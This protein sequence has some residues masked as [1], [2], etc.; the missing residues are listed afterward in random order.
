M[1]TL[2]RVSSRSIDTM[3][4]A[5]TRTSSRPAGLTSRNLFDVVFATI[6]EDAFIDFG[7]PGDE[8]EEGGR[9]DPSDPV[10]SQPSKSD[11]AWSAQTATSTAFGVAA[12]SGVRVASALPAALQL[13]VDDTSAAVQASHRLGEA[14]RAAADEEPE[15]DEVLRA[16]PNSTAEQSDPSSTSA[17]TAAG[18]LSASRRTRMSAAE[19]FERM[20]PGLPTIYEGVCAVMQATRGYGFMT[21]D[22]GG[23]DIYFTQQ[24]VQLTFTR[25]VLIAYHLQRP[26]F[27]GMGLPMVLTEGVPLCSRGS[28]AATGG[29]PQDGTGLDNEEQQETREEGESAIEAQG[30]E[31]EGDAAI[32]T[33]VQATFPPSFTSHNLPRTTIEELRVAWRLAAALS[34]SQ[35][36]LL[37]AAVEVGVPHVTHSQRLSF[38]VQS[39]RRQ[40]HAGRLLRAEHIRGPAEQLYATPEEQAW[41]C[42]AFPGAIGYCAG[43]DGGEGVAAGAGQSSRGT[44]KA[45][46]DGSEDE[47]GLANGSSSPQPAAASPPSRMLERYSGYVKSFNAHMN[48]GYIAC[49]ETDN[50]RGVEEEEC[51]TEKGRG[52]ERL[53]EDGTDSHSANAAA[54]KKQKKPLFSRDIFFT[55]STV[56]MMGTAAG[57]VNVMEGLRVRFSIGGRISGGRGQQGSG[58][59]KYVATLITGLDD[60]PLS[61]KNYVLTEEASSRLN[62]SSGNAASATTVGARQQRSANS[63]GVMGTT[64]HSGEDDDDDEG[65]EQEPYAKRRKGELLQ[66]ASSASSATATGTSGGASTAATT[67]SSGATREATIKQQQQQQQQHQ[68]EDLLFLLPEY[69]Y[70]S[71]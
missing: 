9:E 29:V 17:G 5:S 68:E 32:W 23:P 37:R 22:L 6:P 42:D 30:D 67:A 43:E 36:A 14:W 44:R 1:A 2:L 66:T 53:K 47:E 64:L 16:A 51:K 18:G 28:G 39:N 10:P 4:S 24:D 65:R 46:K 33:A 61:E 8:V 56:L 63:H 12:T 3:S 60:N 57:A 50:D 20:P 34:P 45:E 58:T 69:D 25:L 11:G 54:A 35:A 40:H 31:E 62:N 7:L 19:Q 48:T 26:E 38:T 21:P 52:D 71:M 27:K 70:G 49:N 55:A 15:E 41:L 59:F 13:H